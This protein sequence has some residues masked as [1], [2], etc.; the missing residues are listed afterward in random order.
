MNI[1]IFSLG[2]ENLP[3]VRPLFDHFI[4]KNKTK[5]PARTAALQMFFR[6]VLAIVTSHQKFAIYLFRS[7]KIYFSD[8]TKLELVSKTR[9]FNKNQKQ[10]YLAQ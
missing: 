4:Y 10:M 8:I 5:P 7:F 9:A 1:S 3:D 6:K 2:Q